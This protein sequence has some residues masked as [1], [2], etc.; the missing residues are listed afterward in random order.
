[1]QR[2]WGRDLI[3]ANGG[4]MTSKG[5]FIEKYIGRTR[6]NCYRFIFVQLAKIR[7]LQEIYLIRELRLL[8]FHLWLWMRNWQS[9]KATSSRFKRLKDGEIEPLRCEVCDYCADTEV[10]D[11]PISMDMLMGEI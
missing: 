4:D 5:L 1:M 7:L 6:V 9:S 11:G 2:T 8:K 10:L 3:S